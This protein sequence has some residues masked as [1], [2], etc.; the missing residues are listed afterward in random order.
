MMGAGVD[1]VVAS[2]DATIVD[3][4][5]IDAILVATTTDTLL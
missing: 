1:V 2:V 5:T 4:A 3:V